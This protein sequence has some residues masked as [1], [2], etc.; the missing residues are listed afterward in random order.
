MKILVHALGIHTGGGPA[1]HLRGF[2][3]ALSLRGSDN[4]WTFLLNEAFLVETPSSINVQKVRVRNNVW[5][6]YEDMIHQQF[7]VKRS[8]THALINLADFG[9]LPSTVPTLSFQRNPNY[10]DSDLLRLRHGVDRAQWEIRRHMAYRVVRRSSR[11]LCPSETMAAAVRRRVPVPPGRIG[12]LYHPY[13][14][15]SVPTRWSPQSPPRVLYTGHLMP[16]KNHL[17]LLKTFVES[18]LAMNGVELWM[19]ASRDDWPVGYD[20]LTDLAHSA[21]IADHLHLLG[22]VRPEQMPALYR[23]ATVFVFAS[24]GESF[25]F[26]M[27][28]AMSAG[29]P[30][31]AY[32]TPIAREILGPAAQYLCR[33]P[34]RAGQ[35][36]R[37][38]F[39]RDDKELRIL[40]HRSSQRAAAVGLSWNGW[41]DRL[42]SELDQLYFHHK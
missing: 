25:G 10:Y 13:E 12:C 15:P 20:T 36:L 41:L 42:E 31:L 33:D 38:V 28:E 8:G 7:A 22:R 26:P 39:G 16:H 2:L 17:W 4:E 24:A 21:G 3:H 29:L 14:E 18:G 34:A 27:M 30:I 23:G 9:P 5:R 1:S 11:V 37:E 32:D 6:L 40:S 35:N 19:T